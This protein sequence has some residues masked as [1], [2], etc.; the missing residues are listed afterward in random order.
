[1]GWQALGTIATFLAVLVALFGPVVTPRLRYHFDSPRLKIAH[2]SAGGMPG[3]VYKFDPITNTATEET[4]GL[5]HHIQLENRAPWSSATEVYIFLLLIEVPDAAGKYQP[6]WTG[7]S[8]IG[9]RQEPG[10]HPKKVGHPAEGDLCHVFKSQPE[11]RL[12]PM[13]MDRIPQ[14]TF[15]SPCHMILTLQARGLEGKS[16]ILRVKISWTGK[17]SDDKDQMKREL[18][19]ESI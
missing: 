8:P 18:V 6:V 19:V 9:W 13:F 4:A 14:N 2:A 1:M 7:V 17:W 12:S 15:A 10:Q 5:W 11:L 16:N 3:I